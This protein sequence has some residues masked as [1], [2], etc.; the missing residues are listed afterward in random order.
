MNSPSLITRMLTTRNVGTLDRV[1]RALPALAVAYLYWTG[2][3]S[4]VALW[5]LAVGSGM[6]LMTSILGSCSVYYLLGFSTCPL[7]G[8]ARP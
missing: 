2:A 1:I 3:V 4:G 7:S 8:K 5:V 6:L